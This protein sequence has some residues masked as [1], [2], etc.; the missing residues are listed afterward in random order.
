VT[1]ATGGLA[2]ALGVL[3]GEAG[4]AQAQPNAAFGGQARAD[5]ASQLIL[6]GVQQGISSLPPTS[7]QS[8]AWTFDQGL[9]TFTASEELGPFS[10]RIPDTIGKNVFSFR[11]AMTYFNL[12]DTYDPI[13]Y[14]VIDNRTGPD[15]RDNMVTEFGLSVDARVFLWNLSGTYGIADNSDLSINVPLVFV[16]ASATQTYLTSR[17]IPEGTVLLAQDQDQIDRLI[18]NG[19]ASFAGQAVEPPA[20]QFSDGS[21]FGL[22]RVSLGSKTSLLESEDFSLAIAPEL[23]FPSPS[24]SS[25]SGS[26]TW[27]IL[28]RVI[29]A[30]HFS[31]MFHVQ[32]D[33]GYDYDFSIA[34]LR[35]FVWN[36]GGW[37]T[38]SMAT[39][40][41]GFGG[42]LFDEGVDFTPRQAEGRTSVGYPEGNQIVALGDPELGKN[43]VDF[44]GG[45]KFRLGDSSVLAGGVN[46]PITSDGLRAVAVGTVSFEYYFEP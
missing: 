40:D 28:A 36:A 34:Q 2:I 24:Q 3:T 32:A 44:L 21:N 25:F 38:T 31:D 19:D 9:G 18:A 23:F 13:L 15:R 37:V 33:A 1:R 7:G 11:G 4:V 45:V 8:F 16:D 6:I 29:G 42:S 10:F 26:D 17:A 20:L 35:R 22:G 43:Y 30:Y 41:F 46:V 39:F 14:E 27:A 5:A 12:S